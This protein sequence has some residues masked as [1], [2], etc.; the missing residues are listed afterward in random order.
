MARARSTEGEEGCSAAFIVETSTIERRQC[1]QLG[2]PGEGDSLISGEESGPLR[3]SS[4]L[5]D[6]STTD[7]EEERE[8]REEGTGHVVGDWT[9]EGVALGTSAAE[10]PQVGS[11]PA[12]AAPPGPPNGLR[13][14]LSWAHKGP[15]TRPV[16]W[17]IHL[18]RR[19][20][21]ESTP[22][23]AA[24]KRLT[25]P[26]AWSRKRVPDQRGERCKTMSTPP[27][28]S[29]LS[30]TS[31]S[32]PSD[33]HALTGPSKP[34]CSPVNTKRPLGSLTALAPLGPSTRTPTRGSPSWTSTT[35]PLMTQSAG[36]PWAQEPSAPRSSAAHEHALLTRPAHPRAR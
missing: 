32:H 1:S 11:I 20:F 3:I 18:D 28:F 29:G 19:V 23:V 16:L 2:A 34:S 27:G 8:C 22:Q 17:T 35:T 30:G 5:A 10:R 36:S 25:A 33:L 26:P 21:A 4:L 31:T 24:N 12:L 9:R 15:S 14:L 7:A 6:C 13:Y